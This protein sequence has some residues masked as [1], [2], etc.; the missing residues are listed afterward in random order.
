[1]TTKPPPT[2]APLLPNRDTTVKCAY[3]PCGRTHPWGTGWTEPTKSAY[4]FY[5]TPGHVASDAPRRTGHQGTTHQSVA[6]QARARAESCSPEFDGF[7]QFY[8]IAMELYTDAGVILPQL[9]YDSADL[10]HHLQA[11]HGA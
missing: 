4:H 9:H 2:T 5:C 3:P 6:A 11:T 8:E 1:M 7:D 10:A